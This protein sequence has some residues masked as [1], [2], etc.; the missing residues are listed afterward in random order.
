MFCTAPQIVPTN[1]FT[2]IRPNSK[3]TLEHSI[4]VIISFFELQTVRINIFLIFAPFSLF[5]DTMF[6]Y[7]VIKTVKGVQIISDHWPPL[8]VR[9]NE[10]QTSL[11]YNRLNITHSELKGLSFWVFIVFGSWQITRIATKSESVALTR[12]DL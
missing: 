1:C 11:I 10:L 3:V 12:T 2:I 7:P 9:L 8:A 4:V 6:Q 5:F